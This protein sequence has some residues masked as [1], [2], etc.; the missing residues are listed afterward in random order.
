MWLAGT[1]QVFVEGSSDPIPG[2]TS[3]HVVGYDLESWEQLGLCHQ[4]QSSAKC[5]NSRYGHGIEIS[6][7]TLS[8]WQTI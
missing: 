8:V 1:W 6:D 7:M 4:Q 3:F 2:T 5:P